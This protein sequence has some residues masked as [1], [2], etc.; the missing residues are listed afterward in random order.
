MGA[1]QNDIGMIGLAVMGRNVVLNMAD[2]GFAVAAYNRTDS[3]TRGFA[4]EL[5]PGQRVQACYSLREFVGSLKKPR[6]AMMMVKAGAPVDAVITELE[7]LL[8]PG[9]V[10]VDGGNSYFRDT[11]RRGESLAAKGIHFLGV[12]ISGG[13]F[14]ARTGP[15]MMPGGPKEGYQASN[16]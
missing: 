11:E 9:D 16:T 4:A 13:E 15:S 7:P 8:E 1:G 10:V 6:R 5:E 14:G 12:G 2:R 3:V